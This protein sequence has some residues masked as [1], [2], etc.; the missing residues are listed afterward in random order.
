MDNLLR[1]SRS[2]REGGCPVPPAIVR[3]RLHD[4]EAAVARLVS[5]GAPFKA[6]VEFREW[7]G[8]ACQGCFV[9]LDAGTCALHLGRGRYVA[10]D[11]QRDLNGVMP[12]EA[13][14]VMLRRSGNVQEP[15][16]NRSYCA[17]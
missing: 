10:L 3:E 15:D 4:L 1:A 12:R 9:N 7:H 6:P 16:V 13:R 8:E 11:I 14:R 5:A 17:Y 2:D